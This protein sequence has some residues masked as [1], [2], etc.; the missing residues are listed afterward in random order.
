MS[1][2]PTS[3]LP[4]MINAS[5]EIKDDVCLLNYIEKNTKNLDHQMQLMGPQ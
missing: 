1:Y 2:C 5:F 4:S 3:S